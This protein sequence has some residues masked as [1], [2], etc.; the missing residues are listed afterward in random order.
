MNGD[1]RDK[2]HFQSLPANPSP[3]VAR[4]FDRAVPDAEHYPRAIETEQVWVAQ[5]AEGVL[6]G[7]LAAVEVDNQLHIQELSVSQPFQARGVGR[8]LLLAAVSYAREQALT[9][10]T[11][12]TFRDLPWNEL[13]YWRMGFPT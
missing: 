1:N 9:G 2:H 7:F 12:T 11:L 10:L 4:T 6:S 8:K 13:F 5:S 3:N